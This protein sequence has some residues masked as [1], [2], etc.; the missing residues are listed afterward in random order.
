MRLLV[1]HGSSG[2]FGDT[3]M[4]EGVVRNL[5][6]SLPS[7]DLFVA[8]RAGLRTHVWGLKR[9]H[10]LRVPDLVFPGE[11]ALANLRYLWR[12]AA[13]WRRTVRRRWFP[14]ALG[15]ITSTRA[16]HLRDLEAEHNTETLY[17]FCAPFDALHMVG[18]G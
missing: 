8:D 6:R 4:L 3:A 17:E 9:V 2:N 11:H 15:G 16:I 5:L 1:L 18:G 13:R 7:A 12:Y 14:L 10:R